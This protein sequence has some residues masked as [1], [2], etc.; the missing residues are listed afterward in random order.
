MYS[1]MQQGF[2]VLTSTVLLSLAGITLTANMASIQMVDNQVI[3]NYYRNNEAFVN[4]ESGVNFVLSKFSDASVAEIMLANLKETD[5]ERLQFR[6][7]N[8]HY[9]VSVETLNPNTLA[10]ISTGKSKDGTA[11]REIQLQVYYALHF[12]IPQAALSA[13]GVTNLNSSAGIN[14]GCEGVSAS[15]CSSKGNIADFLIVTNPSNVAQPSSENRSD[16]LCAGE[17]F[18]EN[19]FAANIF[20]GEELNDEGGTRIVDNHGDWGDAPPSGSATFLDLESDLDEQ[21]SSL[22]ESTFGISMADFK[23]KAPENYAFVVDMTIDGAESCSEQL[24]TVSEQDNVIYIK[25]DCNIDQNDLAHRGPFESTRFTIGSATFPKM[26]FME[27]G[28]FTNQPN[29]GAS[30]IGLLYFIPSVHDV[31]DDEGYV[32][33]ISED[34]SVDMGGV[35]VNGATLSEYQCSYN[36]DDI[37]DN[38]PKKQHFSTRYDRT[39][40]NRLYHRLGMSVVDSSYRLVEGSWRDF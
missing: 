33:A 37:I 10:I 18:N 35:S 15:E 12:N 3:G 27:G 22:M 21:P 4:A 2:A 36:G 39:V 30:V 31:V 34:F 23:E 40:L 20:Y 8:H 16:L 28:T 38:N 6:S 14:D 7:E 19:L 26:V 25:G 13:D 17:H 24:K 1:A 11:L 5:N 29:T 32:I 9:Y